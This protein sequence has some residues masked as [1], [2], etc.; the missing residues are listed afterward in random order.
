MRRGSRIAV[1]PGRDHH[2]RPK[3][4]VHGPSRMFP[5][6][7]IRCDCEGYRSQMTAKRT[8][9]PVLLVS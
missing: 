7:D 5:Q 3:P 4:A 1:T 9:L 2:S 6:A 8:K